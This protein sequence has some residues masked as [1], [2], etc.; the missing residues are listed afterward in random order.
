MRLRIIRLQDHLGV[1]A[2]GLIGPVTLT[3]I[4]RALKIKNPDTEYHL[5][6]SQKSIDLITQHEGFRATPYVPS[7]ESGITIGFGYDLSQQSKTQFKRDWGDILYE[8]NVASLLYFGFKGTGETAREWARHLTEKC[9][10]RIPRGAAEH[11]FYQRTLPR[12]A[13]DTRRAYPGVEFLPHDAQ[14]AI[15]SLVYNRGASKRGES[16]WEMRDL[17]PAIKDGD[18]EEIAHLIRSM[19]RL[20]VGRGLGGLLKR[21]SAEV[22]LVLGSKRKYRASEL[23]QV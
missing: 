23:V 15:L 14:G 20:W 21:R 1:P 5:V 3:A 9:Y 18:L 16:R 7:D 4:E 8:G 13:K 17:G 12:Y 2:D 19:K 10:V 6:V 11:V 22:A